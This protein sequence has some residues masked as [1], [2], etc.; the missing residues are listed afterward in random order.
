FGAFNPSYNAYYNQFG[1]MHGVTGLPVLPHT[2]VGSYSYDYSGKLTFKLSN[3]HVIETSVFGDP[4]RQNDFSPN[5]F[6]QTF[7][8]TSYDKVSNGTSNWVVRYNATLSPTWLFNA[9][10]SW[11]HNY[12]SDTPRDPNVYAVTDLTGRTLSTSAS[13]LGP[14]GASLTGQYQ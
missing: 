12:L 7:S 1:D 9:S 6:L 13:P 3:N 14:S 8:T 4:T 11:G 5:E 10:W 2:T